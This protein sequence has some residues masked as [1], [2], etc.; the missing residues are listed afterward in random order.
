MQCFFDFGVRYLEGFEEFRLAYLVHLSLHHHDI[1]VGGA[2]HQL[3]VCFLYLFKG[4]VDYPFSLYACHAHLADR[5]VERDVAAGK[6]RRRR[7]PRQCVGSI[8]FVG[9]I[10]GDVDEGLGVIVVREQRTK[11]P[12]YKARRQYLVIRGAPLS[13]QEAPRIAPYGRIFL[14]VFYGKGH[15]IHSL[16]GLLGRAHGGQQHRVAHSYFYSSICLLGK[17]ARLDAYRAAVAKVDGFLDWL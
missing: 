16:I 2:Y 7:K 10:E 17:L 15:E 9:R 6:R 4:R 1:V 3:Y 12:V 13:L 14:F 5:A 8:V 11:H